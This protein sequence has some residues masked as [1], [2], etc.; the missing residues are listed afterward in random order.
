MDN[1]TLI[2]SDR[3]ACSKKKID[4]IHSTIER[5]GELVARRVKATGENE[6]L[7]LAL[8][9]TYQK[10]K[11]PPSDL[12]KKMRYVQLEFK[13]QDKR[14]RFE[15]KFN[16]TKEIFNNKVWYYHEDMRRARGTHVV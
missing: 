4:C 7:N 9:G 11:Y 16:E 2:K 12:V 15:R 8:L 14:L 3:C 5:S 6:E 10:P 1:E 13:A